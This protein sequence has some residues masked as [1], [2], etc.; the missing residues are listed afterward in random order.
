MARCF[1]VRAQ[2]EFDVPGE[3]RFPERMETLPGHD[4]LCW[5]CV[6]NLAQG[7]T[8]IFKLNYRNTLK[9][10]SVVRAF[11]ELIQCEGH[12]LEWDC[13]VTRIREQPD[14][15]VLSDMATPYRSNHQAGFAKHPWDKAGVPYVSGN[16]SNG[17]SELYGSSVRI[18]VCI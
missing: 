3:G 10:L 8:N 4:Y 11:L 6:G 2:C 9:A 13:L 18:G 14:G 7:R 1:P 17:R 15:P 16:C 12:W 5:S